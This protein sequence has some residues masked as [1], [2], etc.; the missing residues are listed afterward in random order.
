[1]KKREK[2]TER[3][4]ASPLVVAT[5]RFICDPIA[6]LGV[7]WLL[8][9]LFLG[10]LAP[11]ITQ[12]E[13]HALEGSRFE[14]PSSEFWFG[15]DDLGRDVFSRMVFASRVAL[16]A[17]L[18]IVGMA[19]A[20][21][22]P[23]GVIAGYL[24][25]KADYLAMRAIDAMSSFPPLIFALAIAGVLGPGLGN[26]MI[27]IAVI[28]IP[29]IVR[30]VRGQVLAV[31]EESYVEAS[32]SIGTPGFTIMWRRV[33]PNVA[34]PLIIQ[35]TILLGASLLA[36]ASL[37]FLGLGVQ[38]PN[39]SW[40]QMLRRAFN[41]I[42]THPWLMVPPGA[43]I[44]FTVLAWN[45]VGDGFRDSLGHRAAKAPRRIQ[46]RANLGITALSTR[47]STEAHC[48]PGGAASLLRVR[49][50]TVTVATRSQPAHVVEEVSLDVA[51]REVLGLVGESGSGKTMTALGIMRLVPTPP[52]WISS[53]EVVF[54]ERDLLRCSSRELRQIR[55][56]EISMIFQ[57]PLTSLNPAF[58][59]GNQLTEAMRLH[60]PVKPGVAKQRAIELLDRVG[61]AEPQLRFGE[62][63]HQLSGGMRQRVMIAQALICEP[64]LLIAD[65][66]T[67][68]LD[69]TMQ[70]EIL[71][72]MRSLQSELEMAIIFVTHD[73]G[74]VADICDRVAVMYAGQ[75]VEQAT[76][77]EVFGA[78]KHPY[79]Q[80]LLRAMPQGAQPGERL[81][82]IPGVVPLPGTHS[83]GC[84]FAARCEHRQPECD[85]SP[86]QLTDLPDEATVRCVL[87]S[88]AHPVPEQEVI[89]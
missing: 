80:A 22:L 75:V 43:A 21:A 87:H 59:I 24:G 48:E 53:G 83:A 15:T 29:G 35:V 78:P 65:E 70:A 10:V 69:V 88:V 71:D 41:A 58:T 20:V 13:P 11:V 66:P 16:R 64:K 57:D 6:M 46:R 42:F 2:P 12:H 30:L 8:I 38:P 7:T 3:R 39:P 74:V 72:L 50:L 73:L 26:A 25:G 47:D 89:L 86:I 55:G 31:K 84:R 44:A 9:I 34:S 1:M 60:L 14:G 5:G 82:S 23:F 40:G 68:A 51:R 52:G 28:F 63:P 61:I 45:V 36:E 67:T 4:H 17:S 85:A 33:L 81:P 79:T 27:A 76:V 18:Q 32:R 62:Y 19:L 77:D 37:S 54:E 49:N 56:R